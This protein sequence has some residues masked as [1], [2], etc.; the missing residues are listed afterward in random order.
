VILPIACQA[1]SASSRIMRNSCGSIEKALST[2]PSA[3]ASVKC[4]S[5]TQAPSAT[6]ATATPHPMVWSES[7]TSQPKVSA[8]LGM[9]A[10]LLFSGVAG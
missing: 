1:R 8:R 7:P 3:R 2:P 10:R 5:I 9:V 4:F 6:E